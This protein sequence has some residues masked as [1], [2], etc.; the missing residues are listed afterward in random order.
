MKRKFSELQA[1]KTPIQQAQLHIP[2]PVQLQQ[3]HVVTPPTIIK[4]EAPQQIVV[5]QQTQPPVSM[6][7]QE[8]TKQQP[9]TTTWK[10]S[11][12]YT[13][14]QAIVSAPIVQSTSF[15]SQDNSAHLLEEI[16]SLKGL[17]QQ[18]D[19]IIEKLYGEKQ[20]L[21]TKLAVSESNSLSLIRE[22][23]ELKQDKVDLRNDKARLSE[24]IVSIKQLEL[25]KEERLQRRES[26]LEQLK[27]EFAEFSLNIAE[28]SFFEE[29]QQ[30]LEHENLIISQIVEQPNN[31]PV[32][33]LVVGNTIHSILLSQEE[34]VVLS[35]SIH[36]NVSNV[37]SDHQANALLMGQSMQSLDFSLLE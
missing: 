14:Q 36:N 30:H 10:D 21:T 4:Q 34:S 31:Q 27:K 28:P 32:N 12:S 33:P 3:Q 26:E 25:V 6:L 2:V 29:E 19:T 16:R 7:K 35:N 5:Q 23:T 11:P 37:L 24:E 22:F 13:Q 20:E 9:L 1:T 8:A 18:K 15:T 17:L